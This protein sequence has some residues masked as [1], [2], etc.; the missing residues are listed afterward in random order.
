MQQISMTRERPL[1]ILP[2]EDLEKPLGRE[3]MKHLGIFFYF[4]HGLNAFD[5]PFENLWII[6]SGASNHMT[7]TSGYLHPCI[8]GASNRKIIIADDSLTTITGTLVLENVLHVSKL[9][10]NLILVTKLS[11]DLNCKVTFFPSHCDFQD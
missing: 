8:P 9:Y 11:K 7:H 5:E 1:I 3:T 2:S 4:S 10:T 6:D